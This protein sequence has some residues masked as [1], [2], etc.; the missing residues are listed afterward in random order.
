[1]TTA[2]A[3]DYDVVIL[4]SGMAGTILGSILARAEYRVLVLDAKTHPRF[5]IGESTIGQTSQMLTLLAKDFDVPELS[6]LGLDSPG[7]L[8][9]EIG[10]CCGIKRTVGFAYHPLDGEHDPKQS[11]QIG[12]VWRDE[13]HFFRQEVDT[14]LVQVAIDHGC[15]VREQVQVTDIEIEASGVTI[16]TDRL[17]RITTRFVVDGTG[18]KSLLAE[19]FGLRESPPNMHHHS[20]CLF[21]HMEGV[22]PFEDVVENEMHVKWSQGT[23]HHLFDH[24]WIWV[25]PFNNW[26]G[27]SNPLVSVGLTVD[28][29][30]YPEI[31]GSTPEEEWQH[32]MDRLPSA[33]RQF[34]GA[35]SVR[36]WVRTGRL[37]Y[38]SRRSIGPRF[39]LL[40]HATGFV[41][42]LYSRGLISTMDVIRGLAPV[43]MEALD[44]DDFDETRFEEL[45][46]RQ[47]SSLDY[48]DRL[49]YGSFASWADYDL[50]NIWVRVWAI[51]AGVAE[52]N[53]GGHVLL[54]SGSTWEPPE[55]RIFSDFEDPGYRAFFEASFEIIDRFAKGQCDADTARREL[56]AVVAGYDFRMALPGRVQGHEWALKNP[57]CRDLML[58]APDLHERWARQ[59]PD[60]YL[61]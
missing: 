22:L 18:Y 55:H 4:G 10:N 49:V 23:L 50:W 26:E 9:D 14:Y 35:R 59:L 31:E 12:N 15:E 61:A 30:V 16:D 39:C 32:F 38:S 53:L 57:D 24:G 21:T 20:R 27:A 8:R 48:A 5:A 28:Q 1:M 40:A 3:T 41:D 2:R 25:I 45:D 46:R 52:S 19:R 47:L 44:E 13:N 33:A 6:R 17:G 54:G 29:R 58:G 34:A 43:L 51:G 56:E 37:Q 42:A 36:P 7:G 11:F 60:P